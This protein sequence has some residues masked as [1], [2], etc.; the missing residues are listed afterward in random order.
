MLLLCDWSLE[1][2]AFLQRNADRSFRYPNLKYLPTASSTIPAM[3]PPS[4]VKLN[5]WGMPINEQDE[6]VKRLIEL[7]EKREITDQKVAGDKARRGAKASERAR[8]LANNL[9]QRKV[10]IKHFKWDFKSEEGK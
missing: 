2:P 5:Q 6:K 4:K 8:L 1:I 7:D 10:F 9:K 3:S